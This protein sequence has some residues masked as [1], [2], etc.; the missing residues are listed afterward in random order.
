[1]SKQQKKRRLWILDE[2]GEPFEVTGIKYEK[3][4]DWHQADHRRQIAF[5][6]EMAGEVSTVFLG[7]I[8]GQNPSPHAL[9]API[10]MPKG[11]VYLVGGIPHLTAA[12]KQAI[13]KAE[14]GTKAAAQVEPGPEEPPGTLP[15]LWE[16]KVTGGALLGTT[17]RYTAR[18]DAVRGHGELWAKVIAV[19]GGSRPVRWIFPFRFAGE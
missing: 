3:W 14:A 15:E 6:R 4:L 2:A 13:A 16:S 5:T 8:A 18:E 10:L 19:A 1:M 7:H 11:G 12:A 17:K 9:P